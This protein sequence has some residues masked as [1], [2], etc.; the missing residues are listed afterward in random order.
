MKKNI[1]SLSDAV[2]VDMIGCR[3]LP[4]SMAGIQYAKGTVLIR[5]AMRDSTKIKTADGTKV[6]ILIILINER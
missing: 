1:K 2:S 6:H 4:L 5:D 3:R